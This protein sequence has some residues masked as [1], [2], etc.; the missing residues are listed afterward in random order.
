MK[1]VGRRLSASVEPE[2][3]G[4]GTALD[5]VGREYASG[6]REYRY[7]FLYDNCT[8][9]ARDRI[10]EAVEGK[11]IYPEQD[12][13]HT[14]REIFIS[15]RLSIPGRNW[16]MTFVW[17]RRLTVLFLYV[18]RCSLLFICCVTPMAR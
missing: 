14:Y 11:I 12:T 1:G 7:N 8:T 9:R 13:V 5:A 18:T 15:I 3:I 6:N 17:G 10:E 4:E 16:V 2:G